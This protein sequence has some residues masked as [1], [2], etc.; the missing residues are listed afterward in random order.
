MSLKEDI[1]GVKQE[2]DNEEKFLTAFVK[3]EKF[4]KKYKIALISLAGAAVLGGIGYQAYGY[5]DAHRIALANEAFMKLAKNPSDADALATLKSKSTPLYEAYMFQ[6]ALAK[7]DKAA[8]EAASGSKNRVIADIAVYEA[9]IASSNTDK[10]IAYAANK[11]SFYKDIALF[12]VA[13]KQ[14]QKNEYK[15]ARESLAKIPADSAIKEYANY[16]Y[17]SIITFN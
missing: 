1:D 7:G 8:L 9:A 5:Y 11:D 16:L 4:V 3:V 13:N 12:V 14:I 17:H 10:L 15:K 2:I 6:T